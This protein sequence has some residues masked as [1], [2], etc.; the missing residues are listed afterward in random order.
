MQSLKKKKG[1]GIGS[2]FLLW[3][4]ENIILKFQ[5]D[6]YWWKQMMLLNCYSSIISLEKRKRKKESFFYGCCN[7]IT[8]GKKE[9]RK[10]K[11]NHTVK[12]Q[13]SIFITRTHTQLELKTTKPP[14]Q[15]HISYP[16]GHISFRKTSSFSRTSNSSILN[17]LLPK[18]FS[19]N[20]NSLAKKTK[21]N[22]SYKIFK[23][24]NFYENLQVGRP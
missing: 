8:V 13:S 4:L 6:I 7:I 24:V 22:Y 11:E 3:S 18:L 17:L 9:R 23:Q 15:N 14:P 2:L 12:Y 10:K 5:S 1:G 16:A 21:K 20:A 19:S